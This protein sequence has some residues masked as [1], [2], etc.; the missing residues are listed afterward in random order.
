V[1]LNVIL[2]C[3]HQRGQADAVSRKHGIVRAFGFGR[4]LVRAFRVGQRRLLG[5]LGS[6]ADILLMR[7]LGFR[8]DASLL[9]GV[10][11]RRRLVGP[12][13]IVVTGD[14]FGFEPCRVRCLGILQ[15]LILSAT[16]LCLAKQEVVTA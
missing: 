14:G 1:V 7:R 5:R 4:E 12:D 16:I 2:L 8:F 6:V 3:R 15:R 10:M 13:L 9:F 11:L